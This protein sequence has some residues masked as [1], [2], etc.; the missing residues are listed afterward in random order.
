MSDAQIVKI[1]S[2]PVY[3]ELAATISEYILLTPTVTS[4]LFSPRLSKA[5]GLWLSRAAVQWPDGHCLPLC[6]HREFSQHFGVDACWR[7]LRVP[8]HSM[9]SGRQGRRV[10]EARGGSGA[11]VGA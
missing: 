11:C 5:A 4:L 7:L 8:S 6:G 1:A 3:C 2:S 9:A 10:C